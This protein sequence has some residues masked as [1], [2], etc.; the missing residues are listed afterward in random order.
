MPNS[1]GTLLVNR[2]QGLL[3][4]RKHSEQYIM[5]GKDLGP[6]ATVFT[7]SLSTGQRQEDLQIGK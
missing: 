3:E 4:W 2:V 5:L 7:C 1:T 6:R